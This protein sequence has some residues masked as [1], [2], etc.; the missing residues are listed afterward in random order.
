[1]EVVD[2]WAKSKQ[3]RMG[4]HSINLSKTPTTIATMLLGSKSATFNEL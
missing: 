3:L 1:M 4:A 2:A